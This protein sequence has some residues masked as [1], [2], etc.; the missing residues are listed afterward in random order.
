[1]LHSRPFSRLTHIQWHFHVFSYIGSSFTDY[2]HFIP[3]SEQQTVRSLGESHRTKVAGERNWN[4]PSVSHTLVS[5]PFSIRK[6]QVSPALLLFQ[7]IFH[8]E[9]KFVVHFLYE[10]KKNITKSCYTRIILWRLGN[11]KNNILIIKE[12]F[13]WHN[14][15]LCTLPNWT[16]FENISYVDFWLT[17]WDK[18]HFT[19]HL[20]LVLLFSLSKLR[21]KFRRN[22]NQRKRQ[23]NEQAHLATFFLH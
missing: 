20:N 23:C 6:S 21:A 13:L 12:T 18:S 11:N 1:M 9:Q 22:T 10:E 19:G 14:K 5:A 2:F 3:H 17:K 7:K 15:M 16:W 4:A 8:R